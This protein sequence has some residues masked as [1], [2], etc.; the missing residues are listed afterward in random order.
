MARRKSSKPKEPKGPKYSDVPEYILTT[1]ARLIEEHH[2]HLTEA[3]IRY[4]IRNGKWTKKGT[5]VYGQTKLAGEDVRFV[6]QCDFV[7]IFNGP[8]MEKMTPE[9]RLACID[10]YLTRAGCEYDKQENR[11]WVTV[12]PDRPEFYS[13]IK[14]HGLWDE[15]LKR[16]ARVT[17]EIGLFDGQEKD[18][19]TE[20]AAG[21]SNDEPAAPPPDLTPA[22]DPFG[23][24][25]TDA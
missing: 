18:K 10:H 3:R 6:S 25:V 4:L 9:Q 21:C 24:V 12:E 1:A 7:I 17:K 14:R 20:T 8:L 23:G 19:L 22:T 2:G 13:I 15:E 5:N 11:R 16:L